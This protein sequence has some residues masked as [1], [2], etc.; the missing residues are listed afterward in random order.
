MAGKQYQTDFQQLP[1]KLFVSSSVSPFKSTHLFSRGSFQVK[2]AIA[3]TLETLEWEERRAAR[4]SIRIREHGPKKRMRN[5]FRI[6][7]LMAKVVGD[8][9]RRLQVLRFS[10]RFGIYSFAGF[11]FISEA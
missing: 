1:F 4:R 11:I 8:R 9:F 2:L 6:S 5:S 3:E 10:I 7:V